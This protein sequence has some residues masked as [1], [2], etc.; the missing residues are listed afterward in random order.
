MENTKL[1]N[2]YCL[3]SESEVEIDF[4]IL[5]SH[6]YTSN[7]EIGEIK[8]KKLIEVIKKEEAEFEETTEEENT[9]TIVIEIE[10]EIE[11][12]SNVSHST[13]VTEVSAKARSRYL[14]ILGILSF[15]TGEIFSVNQV[16]S[17][18]K[19]V[20]N[21][22]KPNKAKTLFIH[23]GIDKTNDLNKLL[24]FIDTSKEAKEADKRLVFSLFDR[25]RKA[26]LMETDSYETFL[27]EDEAMLAYYHILELLSSEYSS[28]LNKDTETLVN[29]FLDDLFSNTF[30]LTGS[31]LEGIKKGK[32]KSILKEMPHN[33][34]KIKIFYMLNQFQM[35][36]DKSKE[37]VER[38][39]K[40][41]NAVAH[42]RL[43]YQ[44][45][46]IFPLPPF[47]PIVKD[48]FNEIEISK[49][50]SA[51]VIASHLK[52]DIWT[53]EWEELLGNLQET[54]ESINNF[55][56]NKCYQ[57]ISSQDF[58]LGVNNNI[59]PYDI[60]YYTVAGKIK[61]KKLQ[62]ILCKTVIEIDVNKDN[63]LELLGSCILLSDCSDDKLREKCRFIIK[64]SYENEWIDSIDL[65]DV[66][67]Y[68]EH[69]GFNVEYVR[70]FLYSR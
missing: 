22:K 52:L 43:V 40:D 15:F 49:I 64:T 53:K 6:V 5:N 8:N 16:K 19:S 61:L 36:N 18:Y 10:I 69:K 32:K 28:Q 55:I 58:I 1:V 67:P 70:E 66:L 57:N 12:E 3:P 34:I 13:L 46:F 59:K 2:Q 29:S 39:I 11:I 30:H 65:G 68:L 17:W 27:Y 4:F 54:Y 33:D 42:G 23:D 7:N 62:E 50:I 51:R 14:V 44:D 35:L 56:Q 26:L 9:K 25:W 37:I 31:N 48:I 21:I 63:A 47:F 38:L 41:R 60:Y 20:E 45:S 24:S